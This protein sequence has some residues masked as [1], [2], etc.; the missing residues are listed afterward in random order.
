MHLWPIDFYKNANSVLEKIVV[1]STSGAETNGF[2]QA[3][4]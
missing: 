2:L 4:D 1:S 3:K